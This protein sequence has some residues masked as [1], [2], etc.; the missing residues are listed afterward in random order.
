[1]F[2][3]VSLQVLTTLDL[4]QRGLDY[5]EGVTSDFFVPA[6]GSMRMTLWKDD[7]EAKPFGRIER[8]GWTTED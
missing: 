5:W 2:L 1:M 7:A 8:A 4:L 6:K 3:M